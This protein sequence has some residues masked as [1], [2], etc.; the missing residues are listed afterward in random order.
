M[1]RA[2]T[3]L[4]DGLTDWVGRPL[5]LA[6]ALVLLAMWVPTYLFIRDV[7]TWQLIVNT[8]TT[9]ITFVMVFAIQSTQ[10]RNSRAVNTKLDV[11]IECTPGASDCLVGL[12][13]E[14]EA[15]VK[16]RQREVRDEVGG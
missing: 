8:V 15:M 14:D 4:A 3:R 7:N 1:A 9:I 12:E 16:Q 5:A 11:L 10:N 6:L 13:D 2:S